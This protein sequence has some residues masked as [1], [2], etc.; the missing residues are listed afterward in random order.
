MG[1]SKPSFVNRVNGHS[2]NNATQLHHPAEHLL[3]PHFQESWEGASDLKD[4]DHG[5]E[6]ESFHKHLS[7]WTLESLLTS[8][9]T[10]SSF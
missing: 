3:P 7:S 2:V 5:T 9:T 8:T 1:N 4:R 10:L 6:D